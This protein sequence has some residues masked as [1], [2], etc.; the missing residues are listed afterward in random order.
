MDE[1]TRKEIWKSRF[2]LQAHRDKMKKSLVHDIPVARKYAIKIVVGIA[3]TFGFRLFSTDLTQADIQSSEALN[4]DILINSP[5][6]IE[7]G[8]EE[9]IKLLKPLYGLDGSS[10]NRGKHANIILKKN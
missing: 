8:P 7:S 6:K 4:R 5:K 2:I 3:T 9:L 1:I 10:I